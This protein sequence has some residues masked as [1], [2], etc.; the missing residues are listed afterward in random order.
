MKRFVVIILL[1]LAYLSA[2]TPAMAQSRYGYLF[3][4]ALRSNSG[5]GTVAGG[6]GERIG[7]S[8]FSVGGDAAWF[9]MGAERDFT[10]DRIFT[11]SLN[12]GYHVGKRTN[13]ARWDAFVSGGPA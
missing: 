8:G 3:A 10:N 12:V 6:G 9:K 5:N 1:A 13:D 7:P 11:A 4:G 2:A